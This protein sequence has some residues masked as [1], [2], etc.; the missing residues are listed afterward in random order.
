MGIRKMLKRFIKGFVL[1]AVLFCFVVVLI[2]AI[3]ISIFNAVKESVISFFGFDT[4]DVAANAVKIEELME[5]GAAFE[6]GYEEYLNEKNMSVYIDNEKRGYLEDV[7]AVKA[8][9]KTTSEGSVVSYEDFILDMSEQKYKYYAPWQLFMLI[10]FFSDDIYFGDVVHENVELAHDIFKPRFYGLKEPNGLFKYNAEKEVDERI[11]YEEYKKVGSRADD[12][13]KYEWVIVWIRDTNNKEKTPLPYFDRIE[14]YDNIYEYTYE[15]EETSSTEVA[16]AGGSRWRTT[17]TTVTKEKVPKLKETVVTS[18]I[19]NF[20]TELA[21]LI[22][23]PNVD[24]FAE[25]YSYLPYD[26]R[27]SLI[28]SELQYNGTIFGFGVA[29]GIPYNHDFTLPS[30]VTSNNTSIA[31]TEF[32]SISTS[33]LGLPYQWGGKYHKQGLNEQWGKSASGLDC[34]GYVDWVY[35]QFGVSVGMSTGQIYENG[36]DGVLVRVS[37]NSLKIGDIGLDYI[38]GGGGNNHTGVVIGF[39]DGQPLIAHSAGPYWGDAVRPT[40]RVVISKLVSAYR[41]I[42]ENTYMGYKPVTFSSFYR[43]QGLTFN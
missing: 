23:Y 32:I 12:S 8:I 37:R 9:I 22:G 10:D 29:G 30:I 17:T 42:S 43:V 24:G 2:F 15:V 21:S 5:Q 3:M 7:E 4:T 19:G 38:P 27:L 34:S 33:L 31:R 35:T 36:R 41:N 20:Y 13:P 11:V 16:K 40:G 1:P 26:V 39:D 6:D 25:C 18:N 14:S 28:L